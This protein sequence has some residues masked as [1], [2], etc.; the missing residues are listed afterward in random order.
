LEEYISQPAGV[1]VLTVQQWPGNTR[2]FKAVDKSGLA[3]ECRVPQRGK[4]KVDE[5]RLLKWLTTWAR[6][7]HQIKLDPVAAEE[8]LE[9][10]GPELGLLDSELAKLALFVNEG[11]MVSSELVRDVVAGWRTKTVWEIADAAA[12]GHVS[13]A[14]AGIDRL[15]TMGEAPQALFA[16]LAWSLRR[17][18]AATRIYQRAERTR[19]KITLAQALEH[20]GFRAWEVKTAEGRLKQLNRHRAGE[21]YRWLLQLDLALKGTHSQPDRARFAL[22]KFLVRLAEPAVKLDVAMYA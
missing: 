3:I 11:G 8:L 2:L 4:D 1:L 14:L 16:Q 18:C 17:Y 7:T 19:R 20:A 22:E 10:V 9:I 12:N 15:L 13:L 21:L 6:Q 5:R